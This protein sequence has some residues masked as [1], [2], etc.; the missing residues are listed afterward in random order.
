LAVTNPEPGGWMEQ[1]AMMNVMEAH[2]DYEKHFKWLPQKKMNV[3][4]RFPPECDHS[5]VDDFP[6]FE[7]GDFVVHFPSQSGWSEFRDIIRKYLDLA[8][9]FD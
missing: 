9:G 8:I 1:S 2:P 6:S 4:E 3:Y 7:R 5:K